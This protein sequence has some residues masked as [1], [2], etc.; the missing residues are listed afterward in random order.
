MGLPSGWRCSNKARRSGQLFLKRR[1][2]ACV[3]RERQ[4]VEVVNNI[5]DGA[6]CATW[7]WWRGVEQNDKD[8][9]RFVETIVV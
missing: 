9:D 5:V 6:A 4:I 1:E 8:H 7:P 3:H 2:R